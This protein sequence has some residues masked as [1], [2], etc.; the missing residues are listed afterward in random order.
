M[1]DLVSELKYEHSQISE[2]FSKVMKLGVNSEEGK[3]LLFSAKSY[4]PAHLKKEDEKLYPVLWKEAENNSDLK[5]MLGVYASDMDATLKVALEFFDKYASDGD[6]DMFSEDF[7]KLFRVLNKRIMR[8]EA[9][10]YKKYNLIT[11]Q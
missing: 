9:V 1:S 11:R 6:P 8:E 3:K 5:R 7:N 4:L 2:C 10:I